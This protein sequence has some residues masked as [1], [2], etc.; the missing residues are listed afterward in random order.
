[1]VI[2]AN[3]QESSCVTRQHDAW[4]V[5]TDTHIEFVVSA[6]ASAQNAFKRDFRNLITPDVLLQMTPPASGCENGLFACES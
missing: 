1:V 3:A 6:S 5:L 2:A 4:T